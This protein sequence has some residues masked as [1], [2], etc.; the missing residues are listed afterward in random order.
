M[1]APR[2]RCGRLIHRQSLDPGAPWVHA[3]R[4]VTRC[5]DG[6]GVAEPAT[7]AEP[8]PEGAEAT[9]LRLIAE[10]LDE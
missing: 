2:C 6:S 10:S 8:E 4:A 7:Q 9:A 5:P 1:S 3:E